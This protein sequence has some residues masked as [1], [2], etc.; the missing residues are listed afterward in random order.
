LL[1]WTTLASPTA[2]LVPLYRA[3]VTAPS[4]PALGT[5][6]GLVRFEAR[7][8][9]ALG[10]TGSVSSRC[11]N[12]T[13]YAA[14]IEMGE[15]A[16]VAATNGPAGSG[17]WGLGL[18]SLADA[19]SPIDPVSMMLNDVAGP[20]GAGLYEFSVWNPTN[21][22]VYLSVDVDAPPSTGTAAAKWSNSYYAGKWVYRQTTVNTNCT[23]AGSCAFDPDV[24]V[25]ICEID[26]SRP[27]CEQ[28]GPL[29]PSNNGLQSR[30]PVDL[31]ASFFDVRIW[32]Q[33]PVT[34][35]LTELTQCAGC[36]TT[37]SSGVRRVSVALP[38][39]GAGDVPPV[40][41]WIM[42]V[43]RPNSAMAPAAGVA[44]EHQVAGQYLTGNVMES[45][46]GCH[47]FDQRGAT[48]VFCDTR[49]EYWKMN[50]LKSISVTNVGGRSATVLTSHTAMGVPVPPENLDTANV[51][52][53]LV[54][55]PAW[56]TSD[57][58]A[59]PTP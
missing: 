32:R 4:I 2:Q 7:A 42:P 5:T 47:H 57:P 35:T 24:G 43:L 11:W 56:T 25:I 55:S 21:E 50:Y 49:R 22:T 10:R 52:S 48:G 13:L 23:L 29:G 51:R 59:L 28:I 6:T 26:Y 34:G 12:Q 17:K 33:D 1:D 3:G 38:P 18:L 41:Y 46:T 37:P 30:G 19:T 44:G 31:A 16:A 9:D 58:E 39:R 15:P 14:P 20:A 8:V 45:R 36:S 54:P 40:R 53:L 27:G